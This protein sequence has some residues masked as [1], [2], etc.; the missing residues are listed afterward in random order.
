MLICDRVFKCSLLRDRTV[1]AGPNA[2]SNLANSFANM[3]F[4]DQHAVD[5]SRPDLLAKGPHGV[6]GVMLD[7]SGFGQDLRRPN[8]MHAPMKGAP[9]RLGTHRDRERT[10]AGYMFRDQ[11]HDVES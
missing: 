5:A 6:P 11:S 1:G 9:Q 2:V 7:R 8:E 4:Q 10:T 3:G